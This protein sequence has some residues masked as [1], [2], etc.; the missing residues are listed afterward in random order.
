MVGCDQRVGARHTQD[1]HMCTHSN[2]ADEKEQHKL[3]QVLSKELK[4]EDSGFLRPLVR[5]A[6]S[7]ELLGLPIKAPMR[8][9]LPRLLQLPPREIAHSSS[10]YQY[11]KFGT[12]LEH[13]P[14]L[15]LRFL[16]PL[17]SCY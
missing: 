5:L 3:R 17:F 1:H 2:T 14:R 10:L 12:L 15:L 9:S 13:R 6:T 7:T 11:L 4:S 8:T 16:L